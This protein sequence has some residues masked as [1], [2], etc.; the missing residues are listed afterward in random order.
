MRKFF[1]FLTIAFLILSFNTSMT[2][3][4]YWSGTHW[5]PGTDSAM[6]NY[7]GA[8]WHVP[9]AGGATWSIIGGSGFTGISGISDVNGVPYEIWAINESLNWWDD[10][11]GFTNLGLTDG[12][13]A[14][15][16]A[17]NAAGG[18]M[19]DIRVGTQSYSF[20]GGHIELAETFGPN[21]EANHLL[22]GD[23]PTPDGSRGGDIAFST[24]GTML[25]W[26]ADPT[27][28][29]GN[30]YYDF[31]TTALHE[32]GHALGLD[33]PLIGDPVMLMAE[34]FNR[35][36]A[37]NALSSYD[38]W[39]IQNLY[40]PGDFEDLT[41]TK[42]ADLDPDLLYYG[43]D[44]D[45]GMVYHPDYTGAPEPSTILLLGTGVAG[46]IFYKRRIGIK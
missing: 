32:V 34:D 11:S 4:V 31:F 23:P 39:L 17:S 8:S 43:P 29:T 44:T 19:G 46:L 36:G 6:V 12:S 18:N 38:I 13:S 14:V 42:F 2:F 22:Y 1:I 20:T 24:E 5:E 28:S 9:T 21:T 41:N 7:D 35:G 25:Q 30:I 26:V 3:A 16:G 33:H 45:P 37:M 15:S 27:D 10:V 40:G